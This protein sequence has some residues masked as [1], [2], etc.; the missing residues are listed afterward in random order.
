[1]NKLTTLS[2][3]F[4]AAFTIASCAEK[5]DATAQTENAAAQVQQ[6]KPAKANVKTATIN[7]PTMQCETCARKITKTAKA[8]AG[9]ENVSVDVDKKQAT[10]SYIGS[11][12]IHA[13][14][15]AIAKVGYTANNETRNAD[16][17]AKLPGC[18]KEPAK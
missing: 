10:V 6:A 9:V 12:D 4:A 18:C 15:K 2:L 1:M 16:G 14:E 13:V 17:Y 7:L 5:N 3:A 11:T 8:V